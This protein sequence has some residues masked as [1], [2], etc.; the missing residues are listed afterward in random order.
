MIW[1]KMEIAEDTLSYRV[2][3]SDNDFTFYYNDKEWSELCKKIH[4]FDAFYEFES[5]LHSACDAR[6][7]TVTLCEIDSHLYRIIDAYGRNGTFGKDVTADNFLK[8]LEVVDFLQIDGA[9][10]DL[11]LAI[12]NGSVFFPG[13]R[14]DFKSYSERGHPMDDLFL[15][16]IET[17]FDSNGYFQSKFYEVKRSLADLCLFLEN[18]PAL[19]LRIPKELVY[20]LLWSDRRTFG[21]ERDVF[22]V[23][24]THCENAG[25]LNEL[26]ILIQKFGP[27]K[28]STAKKITD[29]YRRMIN[30]WLDDSA[31]RFVKSECAFF[32][33]AI[34]NDHDYYD[35]EKQVDTDSIFDSV[36]ESLLTFVNN[37]FI[38]EEFLK[39]FSCSE[40]SK[41]CNE[42]SS[43][44]ALSRNERCGQ[45]TLFVDN[46]FRLYEYHPYVNRFRLLA[47]PPEN[48]VDHVPYK[49]A[50]IWLI[51]RSGNVFEQNVDG[52]CTIQFISTWYIDYNRDF[53]R[54]ENDVFEHYE[55]R[56]S[57]SFK[58]YKTVISNGRVDD[59]PLVLC[60]SSRTHNV[61]RD[62]VDVHG[63]VEE[64]TGYILGQGHVKVSFDLSSEVDTYDIEASHRSSKY[65]DGMDVYILRHNEDFSVA[66]AIYS[67]F[68]VTQNSRALGEE[69]WECLLVKVVSYENP[70]YDWY[71]REN[72]DHIKFGCTPRSG[73][74]FILTNRPVYQ[75]TEGEKLAVTVLN[76]AILNYSNWTKSTSHDRWEEFSVRV[77]CKPVPMFA[78]FSPVCYDYSIVTTEKH[79]IIYSRIWPDSYHLEDLQDVELS[80]DD[81]LPLDG[82]RIV[83]NTN[84]HQGWFENYVKIGPEQPFKE[85]KCESDIKEA[86]SKHKPLVFSTL[87]KFVKCVTHRARIPSSRSGFWTDLEQEHRDYSDP[88]DIVDWDARQPSYF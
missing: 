20:H 63:I 9:D 23:A 62:G 60:K 32:Y 56:I 86:W 15:K 55:W 67:V 79:V 61:L 74:P 73:R 68:T 38:N 40:R 49:S 88:Y 72:T 12:D 53:K 19:H 27:F 29:I 4:F 87:P 1:N 41:V 26:F 76:C 77:P 35:D 69:E 54:S 25:S 82:R 33:R 50:G 64:W 52:E 17:L 84:T 30:E 43:S 5:K 18:R 16:C 51:A 21:L 37:G 22:R 2:V 13:Y 48:F 14:E 81:R 66:V 36:F 44:C 46:D 6:R 8:I 28:N 75:Y 80:S 70:I 47:L 11:A 83:I 24:L 65:G 71:R 7:K 85:N 78:S 34:M 59:C 45:S 3:C 42:K 31:K 58:G 39:G 57:Q 10:E